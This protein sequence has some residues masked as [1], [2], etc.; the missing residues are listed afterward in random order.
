MSKLAPGDPVEL[1]LQGGADAGNSGSQ[2][3]LIAGEEAYLQQAQKL[4]LDKP[5][6]YFSFTYSAAI[7]TLYKV[8]KQQHRELISRLIDQSGTSDEVMDYYKNLRKIEKSVL[9]IDKQP[10]KEA[11]KV[12]SGIISQMYD[13]MDEDTL[14]QVHMKSVRD[15][16]VY[17]D[18]SVAYEIRT[19]LNS[20]ISGS[21]GAF[22]VYKEN[23]L[24]YLL[25]TMVR[26]NIIEY[27]I[28][29]EQKAKQRILSKLD[30]N[31]RTDSGDSTLIASIGQAKTLLQELAQSST[32]ELYK[33]QW[34]NVI[35]SHKNI[36]E[37]KNTSALYTPSL[38]FY[39]MDNQYHNWI[40]GFLTGD[41]GTSYFDNRPV[42]S[43]MWEA[44]RW[45]LIMNFFAILLSYL[46]SIPL[47]VRGAI[48]KKDSEKYFPFLNWATLVAAVSMIVVMFTDVGGMT[49]G[50]ISVL[51]SFFYG[52]WMTLDKEDADDTDHSPLAKRLQGFTVGAGLVSIALG[53]IGFVFKLAF[54]DGALGSNILV[55][56]GV[57]AATAI[58]F[59]IVF[60]ALNYFIK[61]DASSTLTKMILFGRGIS[62]FIFA[63]TLL[64][65]IWSA[66]GMVLPSGLA[67]LLM[68]GVVIGALVLM[69]KVVKGE[70]LTKMLTDTGAFLISIC[71]LWTW[72]MVPWLIMG[73]L[74][75]LFSYPVPVISVL[76]LIGIMIIVRII[77]SGQQ[78]PKQMGGAPALTF[79]IDHTGI[80]AKG[81]LIDNISTAVLF[82]LYSLPSF[83]IGTIFIVFLTTPE[84]GLDFFPTGVGLDPLP[85][86]AAWYSRLT[87]TGYELI[88]PIFCMTYG[89]FAF[90]SR[91]M[92]GSMLGVVRQDYIRTAK[93]KGLSQDKIIWK[94]SFRNSLFPIITVFSSVFPRA[95]SGS[96]AIELIYN[97]P[98]MGK[99]ALLSITA[100]DWPVVF[101]ITM[102]AALLTM[103]GNL[104][105]DML[106]AVVD[107]RVSYG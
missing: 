93:A 69:V 34:D 86:G 94:H 46:I 66:L 74:N 87:Q 8:R 18:D 58:A 100:R 79:K 32:Y 91:Q 104:I 9:G 99:L 29:K 30:S 67:I 89:S 10:S 90:L 73:F 102:F 70:R 105:A 71:V 106:Y 23:E 43:K 64:Y 60:R 103:I 76:G 6:F 68:I 15:D 14:N 39:G 54:M 49:A 57:F 96:I 4:G 3:S 16:L 35:V 45:T 101:T 50:L 13:F 47:G 75:L 63:N 48:W 22:S 28:A 33:N 31:F 21:D 92:R 51:V 42:A 80:R 65:T 41:F 72:V 59:H 27:N 55:G 19:N 61:L 81:Y 36:I 95:L 97:I 84:Y 11:K 40:T 77:R 24:W 85:D 12:V 56:L 38:K 5:S 25:D 20:K 2:Q 17:L 53:V 82:V 88:L 1:L 44:L 37:S 98:G 78:T 52:L 7:D 83:W 26:Q 62:M 107:P